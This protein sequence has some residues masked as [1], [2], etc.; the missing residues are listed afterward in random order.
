MGSGKVKRVAHEWSALA[1]CLTLVVRWGEQEAH[2]DSTTGS[3]IAKGEVWAT[4]TA[5]PDSCLALWATSLVFGKR[6]RC[7][8]SLTNR[9]RPCVVQATL[10]PNENDEHMSTSDLCPSH[11]WGSTVFDDLPLIPNM[12]VTNNDDNNNNNEEY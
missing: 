9:A 5:R 8:H 2:V 7:A 6:F 4:S 10:W 1:R 3:H 11:F 12:K